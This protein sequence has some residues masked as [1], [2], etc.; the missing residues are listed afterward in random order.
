MLYVLLDLDLDHSLMLSSRR[1]ALHVLQEVVCNRFF[2]GQVHLRPSE[3][4][5]LACCMMTVA[6]SSLGAWKQRMPAL[7]LVDTNANGQV[8]SPSL[9]ECQLTNLL[10]N[11]FK[12]FLEPRALRSE[13][14]V[15]PRLP[16]LPVRLSQSDTFHTYKLNSLL[17]EYSQTIYAIAGEKTDR[18]CH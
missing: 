12:L 8:P 14:E 15:D 5:L 13:A 9:K 1:M 6:M 7:A 17:G 3:R 10:A 4:S 2:T 18:S 16:R 11:R